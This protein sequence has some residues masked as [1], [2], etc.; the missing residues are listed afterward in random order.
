MR[1]LYNSSQALYLQVPPFPCSI[2][3]SL[4]F[5][6]IFFFF[7]LT[8]C[9]LKWDKW[10][11]LQRNEREKGRRGGCEDVDALGKKSTSG[12]LSETTVCG[13]L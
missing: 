2:P 13:G 11:K 6:S 12:S 1:G 9:L 8:N 7:F 5:Y 3:F 4:P 10:P